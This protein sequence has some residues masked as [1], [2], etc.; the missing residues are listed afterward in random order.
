M[1]VEPPGVM[2]SARAAMM[3]MR[4]GAGTGLS[5]TGLLIAGHFDKSN[6][7]TNAGFARAV[8]PLPSLAGFAAATVGA[9]LSILPLPLATVPPCGL[10]TLALAL[11]L[12][13]AIAAL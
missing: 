9:G 4:D 10:P 8:A 7:S 6:P 2:P 12:A 3:S 11:A 13:L 5:S 1:A